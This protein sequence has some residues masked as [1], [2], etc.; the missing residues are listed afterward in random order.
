MHKASVWFKV[1]LEQNPVLL[2][3]VIDRGLQGK[4]QEGTSDD[5]YGNDQSHQ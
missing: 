5:E 3:R 2:N 1:E 4:K